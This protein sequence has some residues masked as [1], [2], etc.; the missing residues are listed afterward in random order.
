MRKTLKKAT[1]LP[2]NIYT[3]HL[4]EKNLNKPSEKDK[5]AKVLK[6]FYIDMF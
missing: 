2:L 4:K 3:T 5:L 6:M 1:K